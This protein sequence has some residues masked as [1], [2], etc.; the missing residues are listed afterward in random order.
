MW[1]EDGCTTSCFAIRAFL[2]GLGAALLVVP[3]TTKRLAHDRIVLWTFG[4]TAMENAAA[5]PTV[6][7]SGHIATEAT[8]ALQY[9]LFAAVPGTDARPPH[10][11][12][13]WQV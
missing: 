2:R 12:A 4:S 9:V 11:W 10:P 7:V 8:H 3:T 5:S 13:R 6:G 1:Q